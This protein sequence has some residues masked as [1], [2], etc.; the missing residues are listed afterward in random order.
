M[1]R[2]QSRRRAHTAPTAA[3]I[4]AEIVMDLEKMLLKGE[5]R[6]DDRRV[7]DRNLSSKE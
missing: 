5:V 4:V 3:F 1:R 6:R 2:A 7:G